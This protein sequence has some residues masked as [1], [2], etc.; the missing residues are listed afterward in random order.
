MKA[1]Q[2]LQPERRLQLRDV[3]APVITAPDD[4][5]VRLAFAGVCGTDLHALQ[6]EFPVSQQWLTMGHESSG[7]VVAVGSGVTTV[8]VGDRVYV[9][10]NRGCGVC[11]TCQLG[12]VHFCQRGGLRDTLGFWRPGGWAELTMAPADSIHRLPDSIPFDVAALC[13][14]LS[15]LLHAF[16]LLSPRAARAAT[17]GPVLVM[18]A[19]IIG[20]LAICLLHYRGARAV[21]VSEPSEGRRRLV[22][23][24]ELGYRTVTP[25]QLGDEFSGWSEERLETEGP[26]LVMDCS[27]SSEAVQRAARWLRRGATLLLFGV[28]PPQDSVALSPYQ[29]VTREVTVQ[30]TVISPHTGARAVTLQAALGER[31]LQLGKLGVEVFQLEQHQ[32]AVRKLKTGEISKAMFALDATLK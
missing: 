17:E 20:L 3:T 29:L 21:T 31:Y 4:V 26:A 2:L 27:G 30:G 14:P 16:D 11:R 15:C 25:A 8:S 5:I 12:N 32:E 10:P 23:G 28:A 18:G 24:L 6:G 7:M 13:E 19:G 1:L 22:D 9:D